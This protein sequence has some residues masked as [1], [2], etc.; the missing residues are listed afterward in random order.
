[1]QNYIYLIYLIQMCDSSCLVPK[2]VLF[3][4]FW[5]CFTA[6]APKLLC[7][8]LITFYSI[9]DEINF[10]FVTGFLVKLLSEDLNEYR[11]S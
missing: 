5:N 10:V 8:L 11:I 6:V 9:F 2:C 7:C 3:T 4:I 1:M